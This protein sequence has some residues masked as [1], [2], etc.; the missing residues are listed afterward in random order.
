MT[1]SDNTEPITSFGVNNDGSP[2]KPEPVISEV[3]VDR[4]ISDIEDELGDLFF[5]L[6]RIANFVNVNPEEALRRTIRKFDH[7]FRHI[8]A[9]AAGQGRK[10]SDM[11]LAEMEVFW[12]EAKKK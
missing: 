7:R 8:E 12:Q 3:T 11:T 1:N 2:I 6:V 4:V 5:V 9:A 10:I